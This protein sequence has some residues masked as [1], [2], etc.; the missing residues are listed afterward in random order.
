MR[1]KNFARLALGAFA[2]FQISANAEPTREPWDQRLQ[3]RMEV[4]GLEEL[5]FQLGYALQPLCPDELRRWGPGAALESY[6]G[7]S[8]APSNPFAKER[9]ARDDRLKVI[10]PDVEPWERVVIADHPGTPQGV[11]GI[12]AGDVVLKPTIG[13]AGKAMLWMA[14]GAFGGPMGHADDLQRMQIEAELKK[15]ALSEETWTVRRAG[16]LRKVRIRYVEVCALTL[17]LVDSNR[18]YVDASDGA[19]YLTRPLLQALSVDELKVVLALEASR[20]AMGDT[21]NLPHKTRIARALFP[22]MINQETGLHTGTLDQ[23]KLAD[24]LAI[25]LALVLGIEPDRYVEI[26][27]KLNSIGGFFQ[28]GPA[29]AVIRPMDHIRMADLET[30]ARAWKDTRQLTFPEPKPAGIAEKVQERLRQAL[31]EPQRVFSTDEL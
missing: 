4:S 28:L 18:R 2:A 11:A 7:Y 31:N 22:S 30:A 10:A 25:R 24:P 26:L 29:Y 14:V 16:E 13:P 1:L 19:I 9:A 23:M 20:V 15:A 3:M 5:L 21:V 12:K 8:V 27:K 6:V 17:F